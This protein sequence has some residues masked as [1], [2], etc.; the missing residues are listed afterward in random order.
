MGLSVR[1]SLAKKHESGRI[2]FPPNRVNISAGTTSDHKIICNYL[3]LKIEYK[4]RFLS[5][6]IEC[7]EN[8]NT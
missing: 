3:L 4:L 8:R 2:Y 1:L 7:S 6:L 5:S